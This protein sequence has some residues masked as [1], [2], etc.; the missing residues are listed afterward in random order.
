[1]RDVGHGVQRDVEHDS[2]RG[3][4]MCLFTEDCF[5][6]NFI[7]VHYSH[8]IAVVEVTRR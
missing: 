8:C 7:L 6:R 3:N 1:M 4:C 5:R 2:T